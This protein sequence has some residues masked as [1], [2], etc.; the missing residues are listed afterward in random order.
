MGTHPWWAN[1]GGF[2]QEGEKVKKTDPPA[3]A[4]CTHPHKKRCP[5]C[6]E[7][8]CPN[9]GCDFYHVTACRE[10]AKP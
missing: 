4:R 8:Y 3:E 1:G 7:N 6:A 2:C 5:H 10:A 9:E